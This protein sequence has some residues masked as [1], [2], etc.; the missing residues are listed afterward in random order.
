MITDA[1]SAALQ[2]VDVVVTPTNLFPAHPIGTSFPNVQRR[3][4]I[5]PEGDLTLLTRPVSL[6]GLPAISVPCG[7]TRETLPGAAVFVGAVD[8]YAVQ[9]PDNCLYCI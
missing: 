9:V 6:T 3:L 1:F 5:Y 2:R 7:F 8:D 4:G